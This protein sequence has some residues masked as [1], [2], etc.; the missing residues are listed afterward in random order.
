MNKKELH[1]DRH[2]TTRREEATYRLQKK[3][4]YGDNSTK[5]RKGFVKSSRRV[6]ITYADVIRNFE[7]HKNISDDAYD[8]GHKDQKGCHN[9]ES[10]GWTRLALTVSEE[11]MK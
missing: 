5:R 9:E 10:Q 6:G 1:G 11:E 2:N 4:R 3:R 7:G 8:R